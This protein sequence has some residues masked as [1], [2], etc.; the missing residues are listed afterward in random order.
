MAVLPFRD[1][2]A[3]TG[4]NWGVGITDAIISRLAS[5]QNLA[6][7]PTTSVLKYVKEVPEAPEIAKTLGVKSIL[8]GTYQ[9]SAN[10]IRVSVQLIDGDTGDTKWSQRYDLKNAD[11]LSFEDEVA[12]RVVE[13]L[14]IQIS[15]REQKSIEKPVTS[16]VD[17]YNDYLQA[18]FYLNQYF[19]DSRVES[20]ERGEK[21]LVHAISLD[22]T[23]GDAYALLAQLYI[24]QGANFVEDAGANLKRGEEAAKNAL[25]IDPQSAQ[26]L[27]SLGFEYAEEGR[28]AEAIRTL[29]QAVTLA[30]NNPLGWDV[31]GYA[32][33]YSGLNELAERAYARVLELNPTPPRNHWMHARALLYMGRA[34]EAEMEMRVTV[35]K[36]PDQFKAL[37]Y[38]G[39]FVYYQ[40]RLDEAETIVDRAT[41]LAG[42]STDDTAKLLAAFVYA[43]RNERQKIS[44]EILERPPQEMIDGDGAYWTGSVFALLGD[45]Q[46]A[47]LW[48][49]RTV[50]LGN[51]N[52]PFFQRDKNYD[53]LRSDPEYQAIMAGVRQRWEAYRDEFATRQ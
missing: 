44:P 50:A 30:P 29:R 19:L 48:L 31:L 6:V 15:P 24:I 11:V 21:S 10:M 17:A 40:G 4:D 32:Y 41:M 49:R 12:N 7:R 39:A 33:Y 23:F 18:R 26:G 35:E 14:K 46:H 38:L 13:G 47:L 25:R 27:I 52:Y 45:K 3:T 51:V 37:A 8:E 5:L 36:N 1:I 20:L 43:A 16:N 9:R 53:N 2:S 34:H 42:N 28:E 22:K